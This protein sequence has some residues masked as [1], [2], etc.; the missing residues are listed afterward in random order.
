MPVVWL[1][2]R[3]QPSSQLRWIT[4][5]DGAA[6]CKT[7]SVRTLSLCRRNQRSVAALPAQQL[8]KIH[9]A[10]LDRWAAD[11]FCIANQSTLCGQP[12]GAVVF[13]RE[14]HRQ[15]VDSAFC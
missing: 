12:S 9:Q 13:M 15:I 2:E 4:N 14:R 8:F 11:A 10:I 7:F 3:S 1:A 6:R 5:T